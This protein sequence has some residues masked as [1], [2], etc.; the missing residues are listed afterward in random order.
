MTISQIY[1]QFQIPQNLQEHMLRVGGVAKIITNHWQG[2]EIDKKAIVTACLLHDIAKPITF[3][4][5]K[6]K[7]F[8]MSD[9]EIE[10]LA[11]LQAYIRENFGNDE[12][13][14]LIGI[15]RDLGCSESV[16]RILQN[17]EWVFIPKL[18]DTD[19]WESMIGVYA[20]MRV[21]LNGVLS[22]D[23]RLEDTKTRSSEDFDRHAENGNKLEE[24]LSKEVSIDLKDIGNGEVNGLFEELKGWEV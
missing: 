24:L 9:E 11:E 18:I 13:H 10:K 17:F 14:A 6:Q 15:V 23:E 12:H 16:V 20:D 21:G 22:L 5:K 8:G 7:Q 19:D 1:T 2:E 4:L 3:D